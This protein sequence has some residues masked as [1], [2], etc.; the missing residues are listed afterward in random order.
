MGQLGGTPILILKEGTSRTRGRE[1]QRANITAAKVI[2]EAVRTSLGP[3]GMDK[4]LVDSLGDVTITNDG[5]TILKEM[6]VQHPAAKMMVEV[7]KTQDQEVGDGT[8]TA[9]VLAGEL[10]KRAEEL[11][12]KNIHPTIIVSGYRKATE[13]ALKTVDEIALDISPDDDQFLKNV[14]ITAMATKVVSGAKDFLADLAVKAVKSVVEKVG[15][16]LRVDIDNVK[17]EKKEGG[18]VEDTLLIN[19]VILDKE[20]VHHAMPKKVKNA[21][22]ALLDGALEVEKTEF[23]AKINITQ[24]EQ[25][26]AFLE[27]E[28]NI[29]RNMVE[30]IKATGANVV[31]TQKGIDDLA[32]HFLA[33]AG[34]LAVRRVKKSDM[35]KLAKATGGSIVTNVEDITAKDL[36]EADVVYEKKVGDEQMVFVEGCKNP[37]SV[38]VLIRGASELVVNEAERAFHDALCV[39]RNVILESKVLA[40][41]GAPEVEIARALR[42]YAE[43]LSGREQLAVIKFAESVES[44]P[45][46]L[47]ENAGLD[48]V[49]ILVQLKAAHENGR[50][51][52]GVNIL[53]GGVA[54]MDKLNIWE[55][56]SVKKQ[57]IKSA[58]EAAQMILR[59]DDI[60]A[61]G[62]STAP[63]PPSPSGAESSEEY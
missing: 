12:D 45:R 37:K 63:K 48:P 51:W 5:A 17:V 26:Q 30:K 57:A 20:V 55:P 52:A 10:L 15:D 24:V 47:A 34:I 40:G 6:D 38:S 16:E 4:M 43:T 41:G 1:A 60:I 21:K 22:I 39:V 3:R 49:D 32:Q 25:M 23:D 2:A 56:A 44:I 59:I 31:I 7:A 28:Q 14:A 13:K 42:D 33:K 8:T 35:D 61:A 54:D 62:K 36:G 46:T 18:S 27:E 29:L 11:L 9:V 19:G 50:K 53:D 58:S